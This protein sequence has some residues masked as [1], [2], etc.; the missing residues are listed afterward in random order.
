MRHAAT[1]LYLLFSVASIG[2]ASAGASTRGGV[3]GP[4]ARP[5]P[6]PVALAVTN[7]HLS[8]HICPI[9]PTLAWTAEHISSVT[10]G[11]ALAGTPWPL[12]FDADGAPGTAYEVLADRRRDLSQVR[13]CDTPFP[14]W[15]PVATEAPQVGD[16]VELWGYDFDAGFTVLHL[17][18]RIINIRSG[19]IYLA[20]T[21]GPGSSG[22]CVVHARTGELIGIN[23]SMLMSFEPRGIVVA[24][25]GPWGEVPTAWR[26]ET[27]ADVLEAVCPGEPEPQL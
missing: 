5:S 9:S 6:K 22:S 17:R 21:P 11:G 18:T 19:R 24:I 2:C 16:E 10:R 23:S 12:M 14:F 15:R 26:E 1:A 25:Y 8:G 7:R 4:E 20:K 27:P 13:A 3:G